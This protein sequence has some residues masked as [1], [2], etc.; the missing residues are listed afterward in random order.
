[1]IS[2]ELVI[3]SL[4]NV[5]NR[6]T[7]SF[8][9]VLSIFIGIMTIFIF[10][11]FGLGL[12]EY[13]EE[14]TAG[15]SADKVIVMPKGAG[16][17]GIDDTF[18]LS[19]EDL[20]AIDSSSGVYETS[21]L[22]IK[23][24]EVKQKTKTKYAF[25]MGYDPESPLIMQIWNIGV[26]EGRDLK[27]S[28]DGKILLGYSY[29]KKNKFFPEAYSLN[30]KIEVQGQKLRV[31]GFFEQI[32]NPPDDSN[33][34]VTKDFI[35]EL[36]PDE[37]LSYNWV[38]S[39]VE[40]NRID[41]V[42]KNI[43]DNLRDS[44]D[45]EKGKEDFFVQSFDQMI[46]S[47]SIVLNIIIGFVILIALISVIVSSINTSTTMVTSVLERTKEIGVIKSI[48]ARNADVFKIFLFE[49]GFLGFVGGVIGV[50][51]G[52]AIAG[53]GAYIMDQLGWGFLSPS[54]S[55]YL[56]IGCILFATFT[57]A[58]SGALPARS[59]S[60]TRPSEALRHE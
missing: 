51:L 57:G 59:A 44:R 8:L 18:G 9:T 58:I 34:Y 39:R 11:S 13:I 46:E 36:Y 6:K 60:K 19:E 32:G 23:A 14:A 38:I 28:D 29:S 2:W 16:L 25:L 31:V 26:E 12:Y 45:V 10:I 4:R 48:G 53:T 43:E 1:M 5:W 54:Y 3:Y 47:Y 41:E 21:G 42:I 37:N 33:L 35:E 56:I 49:S 30:D 40:I 7:R 27:K 52:A 50:L 24:A 17:A 55:P 15:S 20:E 22:Y